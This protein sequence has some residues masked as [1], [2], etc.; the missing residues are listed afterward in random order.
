[1][2]VQER[3]QPLL[4]LLKT[5]GATNHRLIMRGLMNKRREK[6]KEYQVYK[7]KLFCSKILVNNSICFLVIGGCSLNNLASRKLIDFLELPIE[8][9]PN[10]GYQVY[11]VP[12]ILG[13]FIK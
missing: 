8:V 12:V 7:T 2:E 3:V 1:M 13:N 9:C 4:N 11:R 5:L 6:K 10:E